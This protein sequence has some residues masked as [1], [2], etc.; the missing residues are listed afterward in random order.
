MIPV[1]FRL[2]LKR[3]NKRPLRLWVP[4]CLIWLLVIPLAA[5]LGPFMLTAAWVMKRK[6]YK[7]LLLHFYPLLFSALWSLPS[8]SVEIE[9]KDTAVSMTF[10]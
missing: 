3:K 6:E 7:T 2:K 1:L 8:L 10:I 4:L 5:V 9:G